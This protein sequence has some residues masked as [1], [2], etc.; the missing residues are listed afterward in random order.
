[1]TE[2]ENV[3]SSRIDFLSTIFNTASGAVFAALFGVVG[4]LIAST[5]GF[6]NKDREL[7]I[8][9][10]RVALSIL[11]E[12]SN[13]AANEELEPQRK[14]A[15]RALEKFSGI[16]IEYGDFETWAREGVVPKVAESVEQVCGRLAHNFSNYKRT[17]FSSASSRSENYMN[18]YIL[19]CLNNTSSDQVK[20]VYSALIKEEEQIERE[21][22]EMREEMRAKRAAGEYPF[23]FQ[24]LDSPPAQ[25][26]PR[27]IRKRF[28][29]KPIP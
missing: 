2:T 22:N 16:E 9:M 28:E 15:V 1:M 19:G 23:N 10:M 18:M 21:E 20:I 6:I 13:P 12:A 27:V 29:P 24:T 7:D 8:E 17:H 25:N 4:A 3:A 14:F 11:S 5:T 26:W